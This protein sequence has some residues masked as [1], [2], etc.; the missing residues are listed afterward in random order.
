MI[1]SFQSVTISRRG[2][3]MVTYLPTWKHSK[4]LEWELSLDARRFLM[5]ASFLEQCLMAVAN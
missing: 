3:R 5:E 2:G 4:Y 1:A